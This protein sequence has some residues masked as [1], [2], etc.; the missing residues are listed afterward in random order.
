M[1]NWHGDWK[2]P[3]RIHLPGVTVYVRPLPK[4]RQ[5]EFDGM[6]VYSVE[7]DEAYLFIDTSLPI[8]SQRYVILHEL[9]HAAIEL[10]DAMIEKFPEHVRTK[11]MQDKVVIEQEE[12]S[13]G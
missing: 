11:Y 5:D 2:I 3:K 1:A 12:A 6:W 4:E 10:V 8:E 13:D 7:K 9:Q